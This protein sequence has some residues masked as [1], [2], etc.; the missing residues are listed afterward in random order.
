MPAAIVEAMRETLKPH[1]L[2]AEAVFRLSELWIG[3]VLPLKRKSRREHIA[4]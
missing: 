3:V 2:A 1:S 4:E